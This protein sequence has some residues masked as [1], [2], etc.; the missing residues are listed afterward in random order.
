MVG[1]HPS[2]ILLKGTKFALSK[3]LSL[4]VG[5]RIEPDAVA[6]AVD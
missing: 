4:K 3:L 5:Q 1:V 6:G 2:L